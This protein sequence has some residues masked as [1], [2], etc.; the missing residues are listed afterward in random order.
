MPAGPGTGASSFRP[1]MRQAP[2]SPARRVRNSAGCSTER[3]DR[4]MAAR[5]AR[6]RQRE[7]TRLMA[8]ARCGAALAI[9]L[10]V[11]PEQAGAVEF[12][13]EEIRIPM[14]A[15]GPRGLEGLLV[16]TDEPG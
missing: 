4:S 16:H 6:V 10:L 3:P 7:E 5:G 11:L 9:A 12:V 14:P 2:R 15:A 1:P 8:L 13:R